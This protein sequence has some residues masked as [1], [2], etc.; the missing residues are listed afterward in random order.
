MARPSETEAA[1]TQPPEELHAIGEVAEATGLTPE[2]LRIWERRYGRPVAVRLPS[3]HRRYTTAQ[4]VW[5]RR[6][7]EAL[8][9]GHR[10]NKVVALDDAG[11]DALLAGLAAEQPRDEASEQLIALARDYRGTELRAALEA[12]WAQDEPVAFLAEYIAPFLRLVGREWADGALDIRHEHFVSELVQDTLRRLRAGFEQQSDRGGVLL[13]T[14][15]G[16]RHGL[17]LQMAG[18]L[19]ASMGLPYH[20]LGVDSPNEEILRA[21]R[22]LDAALVGI[23]VSLSTGGIETDRQLSA[24]RKLLP[25]P[26]RLLAGGEGARRARRGPRG[27]EYVADL[28]AWADAL[29]TLESA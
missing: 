14:L 17:G 7:A 21:A 28:A 29:R 5:L 12:R 3:G 8:A 13:T 2:T 16:E 6:V 1:Q 10:P 26:I 20:I 9:H 18:L 24:L 4:I 23:S 11:L 25:A 22:E 15:S 27:V 19:C